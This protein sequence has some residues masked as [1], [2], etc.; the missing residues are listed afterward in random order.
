MELQKDSS[1]LESDQENLACG[2]TTRHKRLPPYE[3]IHK[4]F[5]LCEKS[6]SGLIYKEAIPCR[7]IKPGDTAGTKNKDGY[8]HVIFKGV[9]YKAHRLVYL[10]QTKQDPLDKEVDHLSGLDFPLELRLTTAS[11]NSRNKIKKKSSSSKYKGVSWSRGASKWVAQ[12]KIHGKNYYLGYFL[13]EIDAA[14]AYNKAALE[15]HGTFARINEL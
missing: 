11:E 15:L 4:R 5:E 14:K 12:I 9:V 7:K 10:L 3:E 13:E 2:G 1:T 8:W 6:P